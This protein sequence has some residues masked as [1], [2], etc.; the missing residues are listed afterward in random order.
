MVIPNIL[1]LGFGI[2]VTQ[3]KLFSYKMSILQFLVMIIQDILQKNASHVNGSL[4][5][6]NTIELWLI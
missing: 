6:K 1:D 2:K 5:K 3:V 4:L